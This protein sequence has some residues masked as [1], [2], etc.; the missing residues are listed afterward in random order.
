MASD[1]VPILAE[2]SSSQVVALATV[3]MGVGFLVLVSLAGIVVPAW[4]SVSRFRM[5]TALK[6][7]M[8]ERGMSAEEILSIL[9]TPESGTNTI[10][11]PCASEVVIE[12]DEEWQPGLILRREGDRYYVHYVGGEMSENEWV[13]SA[14]IRFPRSSKTPCGSPWDWN[15]PS[16]AFGAGSW[17]DNKSKPAPVEQ[18]I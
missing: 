6:Q 10:N 1:F 13:P 3:G 8:L 16:K 5:E 7:Q 2:F 14:R 17:C 12:G 9:S 18:E 4:A 11:Y 15:D